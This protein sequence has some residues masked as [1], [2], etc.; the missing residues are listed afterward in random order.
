MEKKNP[1]CNC[2]NTACPR[3]GNC[4]ACREHH[5]G[6]PYCEREAAKEESDE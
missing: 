2:P 1:N 5:D 4:A 6:K 3:N